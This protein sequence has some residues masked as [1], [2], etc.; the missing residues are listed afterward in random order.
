MIV[1]HAP[2]PMGRNGAEA[3]AFVDSAR[4]SF[5]SLNKRIAQ[6]AMYYVEAT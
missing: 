3:V 6:V 4:Q 2:M 5:G 1:D